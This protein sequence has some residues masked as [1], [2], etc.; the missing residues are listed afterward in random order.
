[1]SVLHP[2]PKT[3]HLEIWIVEG[4][5]EPMDEGFMLIHRLR[6][7]SLVLSS[8][9]KKYRTNVYVFYQEKALHLIPHLQLGNG[10]KALE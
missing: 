9:D 6:T 2:L 5:C 7:L 3:F 8:S 1:M 10:P 4:C